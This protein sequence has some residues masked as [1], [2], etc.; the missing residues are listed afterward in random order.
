MREQFSALTTALNK[1]ASSVSEL[2]TLVARSEERHL[3]HDDGM[4]R[5]VKQLDDH[6][7][8]IRQNESYKLE[9]AGSFKAGWKVIT[10]AA[11]A[12]AFVASIAVTVA[13][14]VFL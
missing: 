7:A 6:E 10:V 4:R 9:Q 11:S 8:R 14:K 1:M 12:S 2:S 5:M 13:V 3:R